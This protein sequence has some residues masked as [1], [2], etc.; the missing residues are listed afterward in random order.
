[1][2]KSTIARES[3]TTHVDVSDVRVNRKKLRKLSEAKIRTYECAYECGDDF[4]PISVEDCGDF[5][6]IRDGRHR[7]QAQLRAGF[8]LIVVTIV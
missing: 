5:Y 8:R 1:M 4:P 3:G 7:F 2:V 6:T